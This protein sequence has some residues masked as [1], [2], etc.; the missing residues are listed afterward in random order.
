M[1]T[2]HH[3]HIDPKAL[4]L[5]NQLVKLSG[6]KVICSSTWRNHYTIHELNAMIK[7]RGATFEIVGMTPNYPNYG[8]LW[9]GGDSP[10]GVDIQEYLDSWDEKPES[11]VIIDDISNMIHLTKFLVKTDDHVGFTEEDI[12]LALTILG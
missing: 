7:D 3:T 4:L 6:A 12:K 11:F 9:N 1:L 8:G 5:L 2:A 10:R